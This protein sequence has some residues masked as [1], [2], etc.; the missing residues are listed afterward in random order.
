MSYTTKAALIM[1][2]VGVFLIVIASSL[3]SRLANSC[4]ARGGKW[5]AHDRSGVCVKIVNGQIENI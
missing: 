2:L 4:E 3:V 5:I 1:L